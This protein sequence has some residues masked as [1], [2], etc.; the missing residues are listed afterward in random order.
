MT[1]GP[2]R[3]HSRHSS[4]LASEPRRIQHLEPPRPKP[5]LIMYTKYIKHPNIHTSKLFKDPMTQTSSDFRIS[6]QTQH[7]SSH[8]SNHPIS[9]PPHSPRVN[10][11][12]GSAAEASA[13]KSA[14]RSALRAHEAFLSTTS[15]GDTPTTSIPTCPHG[16][17]RLGYALKRIA[18]A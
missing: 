2:S 10:I 4:L 1:D 16:F 14:A 17:S 8:A 13:R 11:Q 6:N 15:R 9:S 18:N 3:N 7:P 12:D 5:L